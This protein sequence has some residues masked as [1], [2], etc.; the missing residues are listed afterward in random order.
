M[1][2]MLQF[3]GKVSKKGA[4]LQFTQIARE[5][6]YED[7]DGI[8]TQT[9]R[10]DYTDVDT[11]VCPVCG[12]DHAYIWVAVR[13]PAGMFGCWV[14]FRYNGEEHVPGLSIPISVDR[15]PRGA[16]KQTVEASATIW[17]SG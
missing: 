9:V 12:G 4:H 13:K 10:A 11:F 15:I 6:Q 5:P 16:V 7:R 1:S 2:S 17:H 14:V 8:I 3:G